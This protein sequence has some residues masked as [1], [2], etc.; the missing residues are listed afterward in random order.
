MEECKNLA[1]CS[2]FKEYE[3]DKIMKKSL[4]GFV[5][6]YCKG[7]MQDECVRKEVSKTLGG[8]DKVPVNM[9]PNGHPILGSNSDSWSNEVKRIAK[10]SMR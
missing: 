7:K 3:R 5:H 4:E 9:K 8:P 1:T 2:F 6:L 10:T